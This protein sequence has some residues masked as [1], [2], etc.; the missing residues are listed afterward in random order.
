MMTEVVPV[1]LWRET[2]ECGAGRP[3]PCPTAKFGGLSLQP[4]SD[5]RFLRQGQR[6]SDPLR[7]EFSVVGIV[8]LVFV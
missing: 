3:N 2:V 1:Q 7:R 6:T 8:V 5:G 4:S